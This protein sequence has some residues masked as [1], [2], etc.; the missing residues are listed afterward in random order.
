MILIS[1]IVD[2]CIMAMCTV[3]VYVS[4]I[5]DK[6]MACLIVACKA[7]YWSIELSLQIVLVN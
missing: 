3:F 1:D 5:F 2:T 7:L 4:C 6:N